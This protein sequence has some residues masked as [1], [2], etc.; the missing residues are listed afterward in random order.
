MRT[1]GQN[2]ANHPPFITTYEKRAVSLCGCRS[3]EDRI[4]VVSGRQFNVERN[5]PEG[6]YVSEATFTDLPFVML[7]DTQPAH[8]A[9]KEL[10]GPYETV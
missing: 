3:C 2:R 5:A 9:R 8:E 7:H 10:V 4:G 6:A 1:G